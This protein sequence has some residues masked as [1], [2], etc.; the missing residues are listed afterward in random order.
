[1]QYADD[2]LILIQ[3]DKRQIIN[4][5]FLLMCFEEMSG[6]K[7]NYHKNEVIVMGQIIEVQQRVPNMLNCKLGSFPFAYL[8]LPIY[9]RK[10]SMDQ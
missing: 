10:L 6:L 9:D 4:L 1:L 5:K 3:H 8:G 2:T 7:I